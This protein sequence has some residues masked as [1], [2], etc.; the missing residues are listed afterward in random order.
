LRVFSLAYHVIVVA[1]RIIK[2]LSYHA[3]GCASA[4]AAAALLGGRA[5]AIVKL[6]EAWVGIRIVGISK[7]IAFCL[8]I[9]D[10]YIQRNG[11]RGAALGESA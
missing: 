7:R 10:D 3:L 6:L 11:L 9:A 1:L 5:L 4:A 8:E 2:G